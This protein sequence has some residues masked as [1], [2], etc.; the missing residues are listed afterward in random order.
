MH[1]EGLDDA[2]Q[3][4]LIVTKEG[5]IFSRE[6]GFRHVFLERDAKKVFKAIKGSIEDW[7][8]NSLI[9]KDIFVYVTWFYVLDCGFCYRKCTKVVDTLAKFATNCE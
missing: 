1:I 6:L 3:R 7:Y 5:L 9:L 8:H 2:Y 4:E